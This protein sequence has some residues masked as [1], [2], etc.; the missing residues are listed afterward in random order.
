MTTITVNHVSK[1]FDIDPTGLGGKRITAL[2]DVSLKLESGQVLAI[3]GPSGCGK[4]TLLRLMAGLLQPDSGEVLYDNVP[5]HE[6]DRKERGIGMVF[7]E[8]ALIPHW[9]ARRN[10]GFFFSLRHREQEI[11]DRVRQIAKITGFGL[12][13]LLDRV[14]SKLSGGEKQRV[15]I[16]RA[17]TRDLDVLLM[18]EPFA[19]IDAKLRHEARIEL[20]RLMSAFPVTAVYVTHDQTEAVALSRRVAVMNDGRLEQVGTYQQ[21][22]DNPKNLFVAT[23]VGNQSMNLL[24]GFAIDG[25]WKGDT[26]AGF[27]I[28][29]D[30]DE[31]T[32]V[33]L[34]VRPE[35]IRMAQA[36]DTII[37]EGVVETVTPYFAERYQLVDVRGNGETWQMHIPA[38]V[39]IQA[40]DRVRCTIDPQHALF[41]DTLNGVRIG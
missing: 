14:P 1:A 3:L 8:G 6:V 16:A 17:L 34:G 26:F 27:P 21:L 11:P 19:N 38:D 2:K 15:S 40:R 23:F 22:Y 29:R 35:H 10:I 4:S 24:R 12:D 5:V 18:D 37:G 31:A 41:F 9:E 13:K 39:A 25:Q 7:Q 28:R 20:Q 30:L 32:R 36:D 33:T